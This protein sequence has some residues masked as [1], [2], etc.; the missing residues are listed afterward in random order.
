MD[1]NRI[2]DPDNTIKC[3]RNSIPNTVIC[4]QNEEKV[5]VCDSKLS[6]PM[7]RDGGDGAAGFLATIRIRRENIIS[8][9]VI[10]GSNR[11]PV[12]N[13]RRYAQEF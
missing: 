6:V 1:V 13:A 10:A 4:V 3:Y 2:L 7:Y 12:D 11:V 8:N 5:D 9:H